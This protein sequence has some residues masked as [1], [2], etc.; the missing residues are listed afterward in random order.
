[1]RL[2]LT[3][4]VIWC[5]ASVPVALLI[6]QFLRLRGETARTGASSPEIESRYWSV[7]ELGGELENASL[8]ALQTGNV[9]A[10]E[11]AQREL[12]SV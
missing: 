1:M 2:A 4:I 3:V 5:F 11:P 9:G 10:M 6:G 12:S 8:I 7:A